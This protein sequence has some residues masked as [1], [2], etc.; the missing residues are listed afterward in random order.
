[1]TESGGLNH[2]LR[3]QGFSDFA[4]RGIGRFAP[5]SPGCHRLARWA[6]SIFRSLWRWTILSQMMQRRKVPPMGILTQAVIL[7]GLSVCGSPP[8]A[9]SGLNAHESLPGLVKNC[10]PLARAF[11]AAGLCG[12]RGDHFSFSASLR[13]PSFRK[14]ARLAS[15]RIFPTSPRLTFTPAIRCSHVADSSKASVRSAS[16]RGRAVA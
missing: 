16:K 1:M 8:I 13:M 3:A 6:K 7:L 12:Y 10:V 15:K 5:S 2:A 9:S 4:T 11:K 14:A